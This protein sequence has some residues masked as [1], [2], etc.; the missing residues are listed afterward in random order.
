MSV[1]APPLTCSPPWQQVATGDEVVAVAERAA[2]GTSARVAVW[3]PENLG[4]ACAAVD[5]VLAALDQQVSRFREDSELSLAARCR[6]R[7]SAPR[8]GSARHRSAGVVRLIRSSLRIFDAELRQHA[9]GW[10]CGAAS[11]LPVT[12]GR[13]R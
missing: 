4:V 11:V 2:L 13:S 12:A 5:D 1:S 10:C 3:P 8:P 9:M 6:R 7:Y